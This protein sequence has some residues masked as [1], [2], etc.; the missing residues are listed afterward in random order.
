MAGGALE[1]LRE[2]AAAYAA[3]LESTNS[4]LD[5]LITTGVLSREVAFDQGATG[6]VERASGL[7]RDLRRDYPYAGYAELPVDVPIRA[8]GRCPCPSAGAHRRDRRQAS[9]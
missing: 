3:R 4:H 1:A 9:R 2:D 5:R 8:G 7:D 6:P